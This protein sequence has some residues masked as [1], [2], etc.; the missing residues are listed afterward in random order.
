MRDVVREVIAERGAQESKPSLIDRH[1][2]A[3]QLSVSV[4]TI[5]RMSAE[6]LP[7]TFVGTSPRYAVPEVYEWLRERGRRGTKSAIAKRGTHTGVRL[8]SRATR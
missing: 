3:R 2:L 6:G 1:E 5:A 8:L 4:A 7:H